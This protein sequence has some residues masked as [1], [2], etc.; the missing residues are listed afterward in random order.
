M[1]LRPFSRTVALG[2]WLLLFSIVRAQTPLDIEIDAVERSELGPLDLAI[3]DNTSFRWRHL[4]TERFVVHYNQKMFAARVARMGEQFYGAISA[5]L[6]KLSD[7]VSPRRSHVFIFR[8]ARDWESIVANRPGLETWAASFVGGNVMYLQEIGDATSEKMGVLAHEMA[9]LV[10]NRF[11]NVNLPLWLNEGLAEYYEEFAYRAARGMAQSKKNAFP[12]LRRHTPLAEL[13][14]A[15]SYP[16]DVA[17]VRL[18]YA[19]GKYLVGYLLLRLPR[20][21]W[22]RFFARVLA[23][24][25]AQS[26]LLE[27]YGWPNVESLEKEFDRFIR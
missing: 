10:F 17:E 22:D 12:P 21:K 20:D 4:Q 3:L 6:P 19:T 25:N 26:A 14:S 1:S 15:S 27:T 7:R 16:P 18:F 9:H 24:E 23:G 5:D 11:L 13:L 8:D 2:I